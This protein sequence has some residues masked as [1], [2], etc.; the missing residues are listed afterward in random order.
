ME[1]RRNRC[2]A[3]D[4]L[5]RGSALHTWL[6][7]V[8]AAQFIHLFNWPHFHHDRDRNETQPAANPHNTQPALNPLSKIIKKKRSKDAKKKSQSINQNQ[9]SLAGAADSNS[10][11]ENGSM[12]RH[13]SNAQLMIDGVTNNGHDIAPWWSADTRDGIKMALFAA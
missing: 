8:I 12:D 5:R 10:S 4:A 3:S 7:E 2:D 6:I 1:L 11:L 13:D 9:S